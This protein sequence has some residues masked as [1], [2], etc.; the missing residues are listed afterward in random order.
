MA[1]IQ[2]RNK[3]EVDVD[4][5]LKSHVSPIEPRDD[6]AC[7]SRHPDYSLADSARNFEHQLRKEVCERK[8]M[9]D[10]IWLRIDHLNNRISGSPRPGNDM[11]SPLFDTESQGRQMCARGLNW[12]RSMSSPPVARRVGC[13]GRFPS[14]SRAICD[15]P[16]RESL[17]GFIR[18]SSRSPS[19]NLN[20]SST[21]RIH[22]ES[23]RGPE[24]MQIQ[25][26]NCS[27]QDPVRSSA[28]SPSFNPYAVPVHIERVT[29]SPL[30]RAVSPAH[31]ASSPGLSLC[32]KTECYSVELDS[33]SRTVPCSLNP[34]PYAGIANYEPDILST[35]S[36]APSPK[37]AH[38]FSTS[39][40]VQMS[41]PSKLQ[42]V[43]ALVAAAAAG[44]QLSN[45]PV[46]E[47]SDASNDSQPFRR[48]PFG[49]V[50]RRQTQQGE[51][52][53]PQLGQPSRDTQ[54]E[55]PSLCFARAP[56][57]KV[58]PPPK[59][60]HDF[61]YNFDD[62][63]SFPSMPQSV[64]MPAAAA[65]GTSQSVRPMTFGPVVRRRSLQGRQV[66]PALG[67][68]SSSGDIT[69]HMPHHDTTSLAFHTQRSLSRSLSPSGCFS[70]PSPVSSAIINHNGIQPPLQSW[71]VVNSGSSVRCLPQVSMF[72]QSAGVPT[73]RSSSPAVSAG[74]SIEHI[75]YTSSFHTAPGPANATMRNPP[76]RYGMARP[77]SACGRGASYM[78]SP[79]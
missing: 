18:R 23:S 4:L 37:V 76:V 71:R 70:A 41:A 36:T 67:H 63:K 62:Q 33:S 27:S 77:K 35:S 9:E 49:L 57:P 64:S 78:T 29:D 22:D 65:T 79:R 2:E 74:G 8:T 68:S 31:S 12:E 11:S 46:M 26:I 17:S 28:H 61:H 54:S 32:H 75:P 16:G 13:E 5:G 40:P 3:R 38:D 14:D 19:K 69:S 6:H 20:V 1:I 7:V 48:Q 21:P 24:Y 66:S 73:R 42:S 10:Q 15:N 44:T 39:V 43:S 25:D 30:T 60:A 52:M 47:H 58:V 56:V 55:M 50:L 59:F 45:M 51:L 53:T 72:P 34:S